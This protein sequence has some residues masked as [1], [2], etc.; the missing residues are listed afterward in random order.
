M[1]DQKFDYRTPFVNLQR[2]RSIKMVRWYFI[3]KSIF[4]LKSVATLFQIPMSNH[5]EHQDFEEQQNPVNYVKCFLMTGIVPLPLSTGKQVF[6]SS[7][8]KIGGFFLGRGSPSAFNWIAS[9]E[10]SHFQKNRL[11]WKHSITL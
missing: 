9:A 10:D 3:E 2:R 1:E 11:F 4:N 8:R 7:E 5:F 6:G